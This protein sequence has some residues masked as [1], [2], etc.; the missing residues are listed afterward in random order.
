MWYLKSS[1]DASPV[2][3]ETFAV[4]IFTQKTKDW[5][6]RLTYEKMFYQIK[7]DDIFLYIAFFMN[8]SSLNVREKMYTCSFDQI[9]SKYNSIREN[10]NFLYEWEDSINLELKNMKFDF[11]EPSLHLMTFKQEAIDRL[12]GFRADQDLIREYG[13]LA[14]KL[15][16]NQKEM[17]MSI[18]AETDE[19]YPMGFVY[20][21][22]IIR[23]MITDKRYRNAT[24]EK[25]TEKK[26]S[27]TNNWPF[28]LN[29]RR[30]SI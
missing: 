9:E 23:A 20:T 24:I 19:N 4:E 13:Q 16:R 12:K 26:D 5:D 25:Y 3:A 27:D 22:D 15:Y 7:M 14:E 8:I 29:T 1:I 28:L 21:F 17:A 6:L 10:F 11:F 30:Q 2:D 18:F